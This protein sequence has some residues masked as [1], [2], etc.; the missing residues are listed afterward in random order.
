MLPVIL[1]VGA[2]DAVLGVWRVW[3]WCK[4]DRQEQGSWT[5]VSESAR[6]H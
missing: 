1:V 3:L 4:E 5:Q 6:K 2:C